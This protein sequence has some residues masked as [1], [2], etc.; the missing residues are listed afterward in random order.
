MAN[1]QTGKIVDVTW[2]TEKLFSIKVSANIKSFKAGQFTKLALQ[3]G[4]KRVAR[5]YSFVNP[6]HSEHLEFYLIEVDDGLLSPPIA[7]L[8]VG[9]E[10]EIEANPTGF[11]T[12]DEVPKNE[13]LWLLS[14]G[15]AIG[16]FLSILSDNQVWTKYQH[17]V[18]VH[19]VRLGVDLT[20]Q[21]Q[22]AEYRAQ[23]PTFHYVPVVSRET[24]TSGLTGRITQVLDNGELEALTGLTISSEKSQVMICGNPQMVKDCTT[25]LM[26]R[27]LTRNRRAEPGN[28]TVEQ[29]W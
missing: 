21:T 5:A 14:T 29:Y 12:L 27:G 7:S 10:I 28:I 17:V 18:L 24:N 9:D 15:T 23:H 13:Q 20:Y 19:G 6:P 8:T 4:E 26:S 16:P 2:W 22:I 25:L 3:V 1:W 11:F